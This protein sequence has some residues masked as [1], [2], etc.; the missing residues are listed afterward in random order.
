MK[1]LVDELRERANTSRAKL[2]EV[3][4]DRK[5]LEQEEA[6]LQAELS[7]FTN[8]LKAI[9]RQD[10]T[11]QL[12]PT[13]TPTTVK[14]A[15]KQPGEFA[16]S[17]GD[18]RPESKANVAR[19]I[20]RNGNGLA[21]FQLYNQLLEAGVKVGRNYVHA[22]LYKFKNDG[23]VRERKGRYYW[24]ETAQQEATDQKSSA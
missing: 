4:A 12:A 5:R 23:L 11:L 22:M 3:M 6:V 9:E 18:E 17:N 21:P 16:S 15:D 20:L 14:T 19:R 1:S 13:P 7:A 10:G 24:N 8:A 2:E